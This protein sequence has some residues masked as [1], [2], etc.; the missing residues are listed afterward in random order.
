MQDR[1]ANAML[2]HFDKMV[3]HNLNIYH[4]YRL[5][6]DGNLK[7]AM[8]VDARCRAAYKEFGDVIS[9]DFTY[10]P[11]QNTWLLY[12]K[13]KAHAGILTKQDAVIRKALSVVMPKARHRWCIWHIFKKFSKARN[14]L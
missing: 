10:L 13:G 5:D 12:M 14:V 8:W 3:A 11:K 1:D 4:R 2:E 7:D 9:F 6:E